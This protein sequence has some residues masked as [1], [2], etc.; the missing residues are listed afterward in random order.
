[1]ANHDDAPLSKVAEFVFRSAE[2][3]VVR[4]L[5]NHHITNDGTDRE[6]LVYSVLV[7]D[8]HLCW[9]DR[10]DGRLVRRR[11]RGQPRPAARAVPRGGGAPPLRRAVVVAVV[12]RREA[13]QDRPLPLLPLRVL[14]VMDAAVDPK[15]RPSRRRARATGLER[16][17][18]LL[19]LTAARAEGR[20]DQ[21]AKTGKKQLN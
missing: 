17:A 8:R 18:G 7:G 10:T 15:R 16:A 2:W 11:V 9:V 4:P 3:S 5:I 6:A 20:N 14:G 21:M 13:P 1:V 12:R 19:S